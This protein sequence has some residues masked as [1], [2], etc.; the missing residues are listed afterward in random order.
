[1]KKQEIKADPIRDRIISLFAY[2]DN[3]RKILYAF[4]AITVTLLSILIIVDNN[5]NSK[6]VISNKL[7]SEAQN[8][9]IDN[10]NS[11][12]TEKFNEILNGNYNTES[13]NQALIYLLYD[14][15][16]N[17]NEDDIHTLLTEYKFKTND[18]LLYSM[19]YNIK[20]NYYFNKSDFDSAIKNYKYCVKNFDKYFNILIDSKLLLI[21]SYINT[22]NYKM[23]K[24]EFSSIDYEELSFQAKNKYDVFKKNMK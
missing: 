13:K 10:L 5:K 15:L 7:S 18:D 23:A 3:N 4:I 20:G 12:Y 19:Y 6:L 16:K 1:M 14:A 8:I 24:K 22:N 11:S 2:L 21:K 17:N 9:Y